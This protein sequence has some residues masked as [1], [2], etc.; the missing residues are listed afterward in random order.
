MIFD[1]TLLFSDGQ[2]VTAD[3]GSTNT[4]DLGATGTPYGATAALVRD[5]GKGKKIP[6]S[7]TVTEA[8]NNL[9]SI[10]ISL[11]VDDN[12]S[13][14]SAVTVASTGTILL[15]SL[16][17]GAQIPFPDYIPQGANERYMRLYYDITGTAP[18]TGKFTAGI[19]AARQTNFVG[20]Q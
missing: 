6:L 8:F 17:L 10:V 18:S 9:T 7:I 15:A 3:A 2:A 1:N 14:S 11:Q 4:I 5:I 12:S 19:V 13:F 16:T 20:G